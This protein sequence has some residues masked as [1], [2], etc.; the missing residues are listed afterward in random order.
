MEQGNID[1]YN[2]AFIKGKLEKL[3]YFSDDEICT[4]EM[5]I[6]FPEQGLS[7]FDKQYKEGKVDS[8]S[9]EEPKINVIEEKETVEETKPVY[10][11]KT[12]ENIDYSIPTYEI[13]EP[14]FENNV[15]EI[16]KG[17]GDICLQEERAPKTGDKKKFLIFR[18]R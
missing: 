17:F 1:S 10:E 18:S 4:L 12:D 14:L 11:V 8:I 13:E 6:L 7:E 2:R 16:E 3:N 15:M 9:V 5:L